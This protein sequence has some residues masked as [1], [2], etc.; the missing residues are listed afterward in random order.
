VTLFS[1]QV[2]LEAPYRFKHI[3]KATYWP[4]WFK[5]ILGQ[6]LLAFGYH[7]G[8]MVFYL[9]DLLP[10]VYLVRPELFAIRKFSLASTLSDMQHGMLMEG[11]SS[12]ERE[13]SLATSIIDPDGFYQ[14]LE[15]AWTHALETHPFKM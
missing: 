4:L 10:A 12:H 3:I 11:A 2:C 7:T 14:Q 9:W 1:A 8:E 5:A 6:W 15:K 13:F